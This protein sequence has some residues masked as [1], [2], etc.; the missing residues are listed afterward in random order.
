[1]KKRLE[2]FIIIALLTLPVAFAAEKEIFSDTVQGGDTITAEGLIFYVTMTDTA[3]YIKHNNQ[4]N[5]IPA[6]ECKIK[7][8][9]NLCIG[10]ITYIGRNSTT[11]EDI[12]ETDLDIYIIQNF[13]LNK[14]IEK[15]TLLIGEST[16][17]KVT[18]R[19]TGS[20]AATNI[21]FQDPYADVFTISNL[22][23]CSING[24]TVEWRGEMSPIARVICT[25]T[26]TALKP[27]TYTSEAV[28]SYFD[29]VLSHN[30]TN[31][32]T[33]KVQNNSLRI[34]PLYNSSGLEIGDAI[35]LS[36]VLENIQSGE[37]DVKLV[38]FH[39][40]SAF[41]IIDITS[42]DSDVK[43]SG[44]T[45]TW[46]GTLTKNVPLNTTIQ[47][48]ATRPGSHVIPIEQRYTEGSFIRDITNEV[49]VPV[50]CNCPII[51]SAS[52]SAV[53]GTEIPFRVS[54]SN[55][56]KTQKYK[57]I[58]FNLNTNIPNILQIN[59]ID[60]FLPRESI[61]LTNIKFIVPETEMYYYNLT[62]EYETAFKQK[63]TVNKQIVIT[64]KAVTASIVEN[65][66]SEVVQNV[67]DQAPQENTTLDAN[68]TAELAPPEPEK[69]P[70]T[71]K[72]AIIAGIIVFLIVQVFII[73]RLMK[74]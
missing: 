29:G 46:T 2:L 11:W 22:D 57:I 35:N 41:D 21:I 45:V 71:K 28:L 47:L 25:Y 40:P 17:V 70:T 61:L 65:E 24:N 55:P 59:S 36:F 1:M 48:R 6:G 63:L 67:T 9:L 43:K 26:L 14:T 60:E 51:E 7:E 42:T 23:Q 33:I 56:S 8:N 50:A 72:L 13:E 30:L 19:N 3:A 20:V 34:T 12:Y 68:Q 52:F 10:T 27:Q 64:P 4:G 73:V 38:T 5:I 37:L 66:T 39:I 54:L 15:T 62:A 44:T 74:R 16:E 69:E 18:L 58:T 31:K 32:I 53:A 49:P